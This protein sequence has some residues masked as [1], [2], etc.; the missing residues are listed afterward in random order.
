MNSQVFKSLKNIYI[1]NFISIF[2]DF[3]SAT[4]IL[5]KLIEKLKIFVESLFKIEM[6]YTYQGRKQ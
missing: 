2:T 4:V 5:G 3:P 1:S 6:K